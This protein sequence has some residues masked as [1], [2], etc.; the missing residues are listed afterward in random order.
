MAVPPAARHSRGA[1]FILRKAVEAGNAG[2][3]ALT[4][5]ITEGRLI[6]MLAL[7]LDRSVDNRTGR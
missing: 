4:K 5:R 3:D 7:Q 1:A 6:S 2:F